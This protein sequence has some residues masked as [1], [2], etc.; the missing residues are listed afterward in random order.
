MHFKILEE[1]TDDLFLE[2]TEELQRY[3]EAEGILLYKHSTCYFRPDRDFRIVLRPNVAPTYR[4]NDLRWRWIENGKQIQVGP[5]PSLTVTRRKDW[6]WKLENLHVVMYSQHGDDSW[7]P[8][9]LNLE[10]DN[11]GDNDSWGSS[12]SDESFNSLADDAGYDI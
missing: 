5:Y 10:E 11:L 1:D 4:P 6:G 2:T 8:P 12:D 3:D 9:Q 7:P